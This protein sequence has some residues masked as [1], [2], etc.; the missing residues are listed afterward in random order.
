[1]I[2]LE[3]VLRV[4]AAGAS[5]VEPGSVFAVGTFVPMYTYEFDD[6]KA[7]LVLESVS[8]PYPASH[9]AELQYLFQGVH[10]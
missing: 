1:M 8:C 5:L 10:G 3:D 2:S 6:T 7:S 9:T 4:P